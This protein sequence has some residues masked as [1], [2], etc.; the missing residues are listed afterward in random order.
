[1]WAEGP[2]TISVGKKEDG[3]VSMKAGIWG[4]PKCYPE[5][6]VLYTDFGFLLSV[7]FQVTLD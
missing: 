2:E 5:I 3:D 4:G 7:F 1:M 6:E